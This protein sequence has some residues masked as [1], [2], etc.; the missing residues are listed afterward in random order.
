MCNVNWGVLRSLVFVKVATLKRFSSIERY[1]N[2]RAKWLASKMFLTMYVCLT[3]LDCLRMRK[4]ISTEIMYSSFYVIIEIKIFHTNINYCYIN[5]LKF[6]VV[7][8]VF[9]SKTNTFII[10]HCEFNY[11]KKFH[12]YIKVKRH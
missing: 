9:L 12:I 1:I 3:I 6:Q 8:I 4:H 7:S 10:Y 2:W 5:V 11:A